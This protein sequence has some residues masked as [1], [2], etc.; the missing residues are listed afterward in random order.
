MGPIGEAHH[1]I[2]V[3]SIHRARS[4]QATRG[5]R[6]KLLPEDDIELRALSVIE[7]PPHSPHVAQRI[8]GACQGI[9]LAA[10]SRL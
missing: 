10:S 4:S 3:R 9:P 5:R 8:L 6:P 7:P 2:I 1:A